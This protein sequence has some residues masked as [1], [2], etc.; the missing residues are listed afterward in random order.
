MSKKIFDEKYSLEQLRQN[1]VMLQAD[2]IELPRK[3]L[4]ELIT[5]A[6]EKQLPKKPKIMNSTLVGEKFW[7]YCGHCGAS[8]HTGSKSNYCSYC[9]G[10]VDWDNIERDEE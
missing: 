8:R 9:G 3:W 1:L 4:L 6:Q 10:K 5:L 2:E 7:W